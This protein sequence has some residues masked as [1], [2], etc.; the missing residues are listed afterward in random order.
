M[1]MLTARALENEEGV[2]FNQVKMIE[3]N[4]DLIFMNVLL[5]KDLFR[6]ITRFQNGKNRFEV[7]PKSIAKNNW[8][9]LLSNNKRL[10]FSNLFTYAL[11]YENNAIIDWIL[12]D[13]FATKY[14]FF[15]RE[16]GCELVETEKNFSYYATSAGNLSALIWLDSHSFKLNPSLLS[17]SASKGHLHVLEWLVEHRFPQASLQEPILAAKSNNICEYLQLKQSKFEKIQIP[18]ILA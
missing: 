2:D 6:N 14:L 13:S 8:I 9:I 12:R 1:Q 11:A 7:Q 10:N 3:R 16:R 18:T 5:N 17:L 15:N 4:S